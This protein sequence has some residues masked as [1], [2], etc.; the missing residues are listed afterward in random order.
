MT[1]GKGGVGKTS[2]TLNLAFAL[3][4]LGQKVL[5]LD[6]NLG[7]GNIDVLLGLTPKFTIEDFFCHGKSFQE[8]LLQDPNG[9]SIIPAG[10]GIPELVTL[11]D[12][13]KISLLNE[14]DVITVKTNF[15]LIDTAPG[16]SSNV[17]YFNMVAEESIV[18]VTPEPTSTANAIVLIRILSRKHRKK[19]FDILVNLAANENEARELF[20][21]IILTTD[22]F[23][24]NLSIGYLGFVPFDNK[25]S[26]ALRSQKL[27]LK[28]YPESSS[29]KSI[30]EL[31]KTILERPVLNKD[32]GSLHFF[33]RQ[34]YFNHVSAQF[35]S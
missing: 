1:S 29:S 24:G 3:T 7:L 6:G 14:L 4:R 9:I 34:F 2:F 30:R 15:M 35:N 23:L 17:L 19:H 26:V 20:K 27:V 32:R 31:A 18:V 22:R 11:T 28:A 13:Q 21:K 25:M 5:V 8:I 10:S 12:D 16:I 33:R